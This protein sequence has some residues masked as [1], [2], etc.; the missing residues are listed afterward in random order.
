M[1]G[2]EKII[3][4][5]LADAQEQ[6]DQIVA[7]AK[8]D[9]AKIVSEAKSRAQDAAAASKKRSLTDVDNYEKRVE[10]ANDL[11]RRT[12][13]LR[14]KQEMIA[15]VLS[16]AYEKVLSMD[17]ASY[18]D[19]LEKAVKAYALPQDGEI[20]F[21]AKDQARM[22]Q[23]FMQK[24]S[25]AALSAGGSLTLSGDERNIDNGFVLVYG[26]IEENCTIQAL[27]DAKKEQLQ[28]LI[29]GSLYGKEA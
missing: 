26:G 20:I 6:A 29:S 21:A 9:A 3:D 19:M 7:E 17:D 28:D 11:Y 10:S 16:E 1:A 5:I 23:D 12:Q 2:L 14:A 24:V 22:P 27:F 4:Q 15:Q 13:T 18:F 25:A 8:E